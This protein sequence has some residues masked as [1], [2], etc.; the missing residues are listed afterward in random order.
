MWVCFNIWAFL[1][2]SLIGFGYWTEVTQ[3]TV[4]SRL[5]THTHICIQ[6]VKTTLQL[7]PTVN[8]LHL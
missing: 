1:T 2:I 6:T 8:A 7:K 5:L 3:I 4:L